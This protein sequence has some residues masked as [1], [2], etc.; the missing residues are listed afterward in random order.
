[1]NDRNFHLMMAA[2]LMVSCAI[3]Q[4]DI[5]WRAG[6][7]SIVSLGLAMVWMGRYAMDGFQRRDAGA[8]VLRNRVAT[9]EERVDELEREA[10]NR[11]DPF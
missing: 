5:G 9:L 10:R 7:I 2:L 11:R 1:M 6:Q 4:Q 8:T 3:D